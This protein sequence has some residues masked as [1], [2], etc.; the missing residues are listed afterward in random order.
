VARKLGYFISLFGSLEEEKKYYQAVSNTRADHIT[1]MAH[2]Y[3]NIDNASLAC[4]YPE[5]A[6]VSKNNFSIFM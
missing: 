1:E 5:K 2:K 4:L 3:L 6:R